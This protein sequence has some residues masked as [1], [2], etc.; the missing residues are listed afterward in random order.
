MG[1]GSQFGMSWRQ[2]WSPEVIDCLETS[3]EF[4]EGLFKILWVVPVCIKWWRASWMHPKILRTLEIP[5][6]V[7]CCS[8]LK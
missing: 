3:Y 1:L 4:S 7:M 6:S 5:I 2:D 8:N